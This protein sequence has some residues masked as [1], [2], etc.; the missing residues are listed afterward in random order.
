MKRYRWS[1]MTP[2]RITGNTPDELEERARAQVSELTGVPADRLAVADSYTISQVP[3][4]DVPDH[5]LDSVTREI[6]DRAG[7]DRLYAGLSVREPLPDDRWEKLA[8][9]VGDQ[10]SQ[11]RAVHAASVDAGNEDITSYAI[12]D[13]LRAVQARMEES[14]GT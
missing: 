1:M 4:P 5:R 8:R 7:G 2:E 12:A 11:A 9:W 10:L 14:D 13:A 3:G 6:R